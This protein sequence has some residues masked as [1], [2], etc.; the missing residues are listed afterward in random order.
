MGLNFPFVLLFQIKSGFHGTLRSPAL[1]NSLRHS[2]GVLTRAGLCP[3]RRRTPLLYAAAGLASARLPGM[4]F[5]RQAGCGGSG[6]EL[7]VRCARLPA[8]AEAPPAFLRG[9]GWGG[10]EAAAPPAP[11]PGLSSDRKLAGGWGAA[12]PAGQLSPRSPAA[13]D[14]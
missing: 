5:I 11:L 13:G 14:A 6:W 7:G 4:V 12:P 8:P 2:S 10:A 1:G 9:A 3:L